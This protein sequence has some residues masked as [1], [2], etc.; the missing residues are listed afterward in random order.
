MEGEKKARG[1]LAS[2]LSLRL[3]CE[4]FVTCDVTMQNLGKTL[5]L[6]I[7]YCDV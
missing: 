4:A 3:R 7:Y 2:T 1:M 5:S 6:L